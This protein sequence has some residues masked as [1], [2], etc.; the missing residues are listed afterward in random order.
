MLP[1]LLIGLLVGAKGM[2]DWSIQVGGIQDGTYPAGNG[3]VHDYAGGA[4]IA[5]DFSGNVSFGATRL[6]ARGSVAAFVMHVTAS[7]AIDWVIQVDGTDEAKAHAIADDDRGGVLV[8]GE[9]RG[10]ASFGS[11]TLASRP[12][13]TN[14][15][16]MRVTAMG[17][18]DWAVQVEGSL[19]CMSTGYG[20]AND[21]VGGA[22]VTGAFSGNATFGGRSLASRNS[23]AF[24]MHVTRL[25]VIAWVTHLG[26]AFEDLA[27]GIVAD[28][29]GGG[30]VTGEF[31][32]Q[33]TFGATTLTSRGAADAFVVRVTESGVIEWAASVLATTNS[34]GYGIATDGVGGAH[35]TGKFRGLAMF[36]STSLSGFDF[37]DVF[38]MHVT[39]YG[40]IDWAVQAGG[41][42]SDGG[43]GITTD[44]VGGAL[45]TG[46]FRSE[47]TFGPTVLTSE[48][49]SD[50]FVM[51]VT[52]LG[53]IDWAVK[54][55]GKLEGAGFGIALKVY[56]DT[57]MVG[58]ARPNNT[59][60]GALV[61]GYFKGSELF[62][63][64]TYSSGGTSCFIASLM[65]PPS[66]PP[67][68]PLMQPPPLSPLPP[69]SWGP[70]S[71]PASP[72]LPEPA[73][74]L[75]PL[76]PMSWGPHSP[77]ARPPL[78][79]PAPPL[80]PLP[81]MSWG[82][83]SPP[84][85]P[86]A[87]PPP[88]KPPL[89]EPAKPPLP[90]P[91]PPLSP[92]PPMPWGSHGPPAKPPAEPPAKPPPAK[93]PLPEPSKPPLAPEPAKA[94]LA[95][96]PAPELVPSA[97]SIQASSIDFF[98]RPVEV[99]ALTST[100]VLVALLALVTLLLL[101]SYRRYR[102]LA[103]NFHISRQRAQLDMKI[104]EHRLENARS[105][106]PG[107]PRP[108]SEEGGVTIPPGPPSSN[109]LSRNGSFI[110][111]EDLSAT[112]SFDKG[113]DFAGHAIFE[114]EA[115]EVL[116]LM[117]GKMP[118]AH[119][120]D[121][122]SKPS[123][124]AGPLEISQLETSKG[125]KSGATP[126][127][128]KFLRRGE[129]MLAGM[130]GYY[131]KG[132]DMQSLAMRSGSEGVDMQSLATR[133][134]PDA[135]DKGSKRGRTSQTTSTASV[136]DDSDT[137]SSIG[138]TSPREELERRAVRTQ[139]DAE[140]AAPHLARTAV[141]K[142]SKAPTMPKGHGPWHA[143]AAEMEKRWSQE[144]HAA[145]PD[146][147][148]RWSQEGHAAMN[149]FSMADLN[150]GNLD[151]GADGSVGTGSSA[152]EM[153]KRWS[154]EGHAAAADVERRWSQEGHAAMNAFSMADLNWGDLD[155]GADGSVG[156][157]SS[158]SSSPL[159]VP[160][161]TTASCT[162][163]VTPGLAMFPSRAAISNLLGTE[164]PS[165]TV[166][167]MIET[168]RAE[169]E[170]CARI[171]QLLTDPDQ[172][173]EVRSKLHAMWSSH[174]DALCRMQNWLA[175]RRAAA[176]SV[177][178]NSSTTH[179]ATQPSSCSSP[180]T[181]AAVA[182]DITASLRLPVANADMM[183]T[184]CQYQAPTT[185]QPETTEPTLLDHVLLSPLEVS[186]RE[187]VALSITIRDLSPPV[188]S[189]REE[190]ALNLLMGVSPRVSPREEAALNLLMGVSPRVSPREEAALNLLMGVSP[191]VS[192]REEAALDLTMRD[193]KPVWLES[194]QGSETGLHEKS[195]DPLRAL[196]EIQ[197]IVESAPEIA[198]PP[199]PATVPPLPQANFCQWLPLP[200]AGL[201]LPAAG[202][203][204]PA[205][206][207]P[208]SERDWQMFA[209]S[210]RQAAHYVPPSVG[211]MPAPL[212]VD[213]AF[214]GD[215][216]R[217]KGLANKRGPYR[218]KPIDEA[219]WE[220]AEAAGWK[221]H[222][223]KQS[224]WTSPSGHYCESMAAVKRFMAERSGLAAPSAGP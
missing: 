224:A 51:H 163:G 9:F 219:L 122:Q 177:S 175:T 135:S 15:F 32:G 90:E 216:V 172:S 65:P 155:G 137:R 208:I 94:P 47:A 99:V 17:A 193:G 213:T 119:L 8:T 62:G 199:R 2:A 63:F 218:V 73:P 109:G 196:Q 24:V 217:R 88:A 204:L 97:L 132:Q 27:R 108:S 118:A 35:V 178:S 93:P 151:G 84:A 39:A 53:V 181:S 92:L 87:K 205:A 74:P 176:G 124:A 131:F 113:G 192:P 201:P 46:G 134:S 61:T 106:K 211:A 21:G 141:L 116:A 166:S 76:P 18:I 200:A 223:T 129:A 104:M 171:A 148:R 158:S 28:G 56:P 43:Y 188:L 4:F 142:V 29:M 156:T 165:E 189:P 143:A 186:P 11:T 33:A 103:N 162:P 138:N 153:E 75:S 42:S 100:A 144:G 98:S 202:L 147:E 180:I 183:M 23:D 182:L 78:P 179:H 110:G 64:K 7:G 164:A 68:P 161:V 105:G 215:T 79:E 25:G 168:V 185:S 107:D 149:T 37:Y 133:S 115:A 150:W 5:G 203:P 38:V 48:G 81:P 40:V 167:V 139:L 209:A 221:R 159:R 30:F 59:I 10:M 145:A 66:L 69:M 85:K 3:I 207:L 214:E 210:Q 160:P 114:L 194:L 123:R 101:C 169:Q 130:S 120:G 86:P 191:R 140:W 170:V 54:A 222:K 6:T 1:G 212:P 126:I 49:L 44:G 102:R 128:S 89:P 198:A 26:G 136:D 41:T 57:F 127:S 55:G 173:T 174:H 190:A 67:M 20:V 121:L 52:A 83:H 91:A 125:R 72:P 58:I 71:P 60:Q 82:P 111:G 112:G 12:D 146:V 80:S 13:S 34:Y 154:Q 22:L 152:A 31:R 220:G 206:G 14:A 184:T 195:D 197:M 50:V 70:H 117:I 96:A 45:V 187:D 157:G 16:L 36:G 95:P 77:P 19:G